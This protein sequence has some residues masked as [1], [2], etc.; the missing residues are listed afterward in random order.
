MLTKI[1]N[2]GS[3]NRIPG[4][5]CVDSTVAGEQRAGRGSGSGEMAYAAKIAI[6]TL[7]TVAS[8]HTIRLFT[9]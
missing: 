1:R 9:K 4:N 8:T 5:I 3:R 6:T 7:K 2:S